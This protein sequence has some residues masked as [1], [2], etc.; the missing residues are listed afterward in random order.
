MGPLGQGPQVPGV[1]IP[2]RPALR[3]SVQQEAARVPMSTR[4][5]RGRLQQDAGR[6]LEG[7]WGDRGKSGLAHSAQAAPGT[8]SSWHRFPGTD[9]HLP[10]GSSPS[11]LGPLDFIHSLSGIWRARRGG[12]RARGT[13]HAALS[14][15]RERPPAQGPAT[16]LQHPTSPFRVTEHPTPH[17]RERDGQANGSRS[18]PQH[19]R[20]LQSLL[21]QTLEHPGRAQHGQAWE[22]R[23]VRP[24]RRGRCC[25]LFHNRGSSLMRFL[26]QII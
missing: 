21:R 20:C 17:R 24:A 2:G 12:Q 4:E 25:C 6:W 10:S 3:G 19:T 14:P 11:L 9:S 18:C 13:R 26:R 5:L 1:A 22:T 23:R 16:N 8:G 15:H 7:S